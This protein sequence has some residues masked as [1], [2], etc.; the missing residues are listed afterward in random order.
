MND[1]NTTTFYYSLPGSTPVT[2]W[3]MVATL[4]QATLEVLRQIIREEIEAAFEQRDQRGLDSLLA[5]ISEQVDEQEEIAAVLAT[6]TP[7]E[8]E[9]LVQRVKVRKGGE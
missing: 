7:D 3:S 1:F 4:N 9:T 2:Q 5:D 8:W 6:M